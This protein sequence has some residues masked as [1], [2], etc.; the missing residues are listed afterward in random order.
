LQLAWASVFQT[1][2]FSIDAHLFKSLKLRQSVATIQME[3][4][5]IE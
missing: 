2:F 4:D 5:G 1:E 3:H